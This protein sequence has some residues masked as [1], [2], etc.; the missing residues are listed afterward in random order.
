MAKA[1]SAI[2]EGLHSLTPHLMFDD[3]A[4]AI[5]WYKRAF[6]AQEVGGRAVG[7]DGKIM[8]A[9]IRIGDSAIYLN[10]VM[11]GGKS[12]KALGGSS[13]GLWIYTQDADALFNRAV[14]AG[15]AIAPHMGQM[16]DQ[17]WGDRC[18]TVID[19]CG[20]RAQ[21]EGS[22]TQG[23][24]A[25]LHERMTIAAGGAADTNFHAYRLLRMHE[26]PGVID[27]HFVDRPDVHV[28]GLGEPALPVVAPA[29]AN[30]LY[31]ATG[32]RLRELPLD[33]Q[34]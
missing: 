3:A 18:G 7:P 31:R 5:E 16:Q 8:H 4:G 23:L 30:A 17:F 14:A 27:V 12:P 22:I 2:P 20:A 13:I 21:I 1:K 33:P 10:D 32:H 19:P 28:T 9:Q 6:G 34:G 26:A 11:G 15:A 29:L 24:S 25:A